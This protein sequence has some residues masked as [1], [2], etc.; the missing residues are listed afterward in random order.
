MDKT[1]CV[2]RQC[3]LTAAHRW[4]VTYQK[5]LFVGANLFRRDTNCG[6]S[7]GSEKNLHA[8][9]R[10]KEQAAEIRFWPH[11]TS[12]GV[13]PLS[14]ISKSTKCQYTLPCP[15]LSRIRK[16]RQQA[17]QPLRDCCTNRQLWHNGS[18]FEIQPLLGLSFMLASK[19]WS[20]GQVS[21]ARGGIAGKPPREVVSPSTGSGQ[22]F[23]SQN[24]E[25]SRH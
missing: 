24:P 8:S 22:V 6:I 15:P 14:K 20:S 16:L 3:F 18:R 2:R 17:N 12:K 4:V 1:T 11:W 19:S 9:L 25:V 13:P 23:S 5:F 7:R 21:P 10:E